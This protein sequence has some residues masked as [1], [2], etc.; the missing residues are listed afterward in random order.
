MHGKLIY[1]IYIIRGTEIFHQA[2]QITEKPRGVV[3]WGNGNNP[4]S[5]GEKFVIMNKWRVWEIDD[6]IRVSHNESPY[7][8]S[9]SS[10]SLLAFSHVCVDN[11]T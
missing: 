4:R 8:S 1:R 11:F 6:V 5:G 2:K 9:V 7:E 3:G 10:H